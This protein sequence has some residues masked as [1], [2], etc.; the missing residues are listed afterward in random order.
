MENSKKVTVS[1]Q[2]IEKNIQGK[3]DY[4]QMHYLSTILQRQLDFDTRKFAMIKLI[5][6]YESKC[7]F[8]E[9][10]KLMKGAS[11]INTTFNGKMQDFIKAATLFIRAGDTYSADVLF[12]EAAALGNQ[13]QKFKIK[14]IKKEAYKT[15]A[16]VYI[17]KDKRSHAMQ[18]CEKILTLDLREDERKEIEKTLLELYGRLGKISEYQTLKRKL[19]SNL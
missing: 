8:L 15:Q 14:E 18:I 12:S 19:E 2:D 13:E 6:L 10:A 1:K 7:M 16:K 9:A 11:E 5:H 3:G 17:G 4:V